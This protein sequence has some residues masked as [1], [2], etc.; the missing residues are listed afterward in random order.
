[1]MPM[2]MQSRLKEATEDNP[3]YARMDVYEAPERYREK[4]D[5]PYMTATVAVTGVVYDEDSY[6]PFV[7]MSVIDDPVAGE[8]S[9]YHRTAGFGDY[10]TTGLSE[11]NGT[12]LDK[13]PE[14]QQKY[15]TFV[16]MH[17]NAP[18][19]VHGRLYE[20]TPIYLEWDKEQKYPRFNEIE[21]TTKQWDLANETLQ[22]G[23]NIRSLDDA[24][25]WL[26]ENHPAYIVG[27]SVVQQC[28][29]GDFYMSGVPNVDYGEGY[30]KTHEDRLAFAQEEA[31]RYGVTLGSERAEDVLKELQSSDEKKERPLP[32]L[33]GIRMESENQLELE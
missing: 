9:I 19:M 1:M 30:Y 13:T 10:L 5:K 2:D 11:V 22:D 26:L 17:E 28:P 4:D 15:D 27:S 25:K 33:S 16:D 8:A 14:L 18:Y 24:R 20:E 7:R 21:G 6:E 32:D 29:S 12:L 3:V 23:S 31:D